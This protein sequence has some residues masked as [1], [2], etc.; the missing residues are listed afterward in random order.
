MSRYDIAPPSCVDFPWH[1]K[2]PQI[3]WL[4][5][6]FTRSSDLFQSFALL[7]AAIFHHLRP[8]YGA[9]PP[10]TALD[11]GNIWWPDNAAPLNKGSMDDRCY[12][13]S[14]SLIWRSYVLWS[15]HRSRIAASSMFTYRARRHTI[16]MAALPQRG[17][18]MR[19]RGHGLVE[20][21]TFPVQVTG[22]SPADIPNTR[23]KRNGVRKLP[24]LRFAHLPPFGLQTIRPSLVLS[25]R[26]AVA[27]AFAPVH[28]E[29]SNNHH[30]VA[31]P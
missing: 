10:G 26:P 31:I 16:P 29:R 11:V 13:D 30:S 12:E 27:S 3:T 15:R 4:S 28:S 23:V 7:L 2:D 14:P 24:R 8:G 5:A 22:P 20:W 6:R 1:L 21:Y 19:S 18:R 25:S 9:P 17:L